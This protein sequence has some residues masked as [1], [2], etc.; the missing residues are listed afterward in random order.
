MTEK[1]V[2]HFP[3]LKE[4]VLTHWV[5]SKSGFY[6]DCTFGQGGH[7]KALLEL[8]DSKGSLLGIDIDPSCVECGSELE[9]RD[10]RFKFE[11]INYSSLYSYWVKNK[12]PKVSGILLDLGFSTAQ[13]Q[14]PSRSFS[15]NSTSSSLEL[16]YGL[17]GKSVYEILNEY[18]EHKLNWIFKHYGNLRESKDLAQAILK[19]R[20][21]EPITNIE[22]LK[23]II[24]NNR[25]FQKTRYNKN[26]I[27]LL[28]QALRI[29]AN[30]E[31]D[32][33]K[34]TLEKVKDI[35]EVGGKLL[36]ITFQSLEDEL[37]EDWKRKYS[38]PIKIPDLGETIPPLF[39]LH[40]D[41]P[42]LPS[43]EEIELNWA[44]RSSKLWVFTKLR[45]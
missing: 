1:E 39:Q 45:E 9:G 13:L 16:R 25:L 24:T 40:P 42:I 30:N 28:F 38:Y 43:R 31:L 21:K 5:S 22:Q 27:K 19:E 37:I 17:D 4:E 7:S 11:N 20:K 14:D 36:I 18:P 23:A 10:S 12:L 2:V 15:Y 41:S 32:N 35:L 44:S 29:E 26:Q 3:V 33:L 6:I 8:L 34:Q